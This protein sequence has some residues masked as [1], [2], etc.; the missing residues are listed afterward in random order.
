MVDAAE[1]QH[2]LVATGSRITG[3]CLCHHCSPVGV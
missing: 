2:L 3:L 1:L